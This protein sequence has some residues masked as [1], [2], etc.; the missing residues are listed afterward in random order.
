MIESWIAFFVASSRSESFLS[1]VYR[2]IV[3]SGLKVLI[4]PCNIVMETRDPLGK[5]KRRKYHLPRVFRAPT[6]P[7]QI[8]S[9]INLKITLKSIQKQRQIHVK[10]IAKNQ[11]LR[12]FVLESAVLKCRFFFRLAGLLESAVLKCRV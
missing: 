9:Q 10:N 1:S 11:N 12:R 2:S 8:A 4:H 5:K 3:A 7:P 6:G